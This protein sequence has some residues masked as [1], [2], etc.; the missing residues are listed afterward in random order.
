M[1]KDTEDI[2]RALQMIYE[3]QQETFDR[4]SAQLAQYHKDFSLTQFAQNIYGCTV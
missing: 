2:R 4:I 3:N 1:E